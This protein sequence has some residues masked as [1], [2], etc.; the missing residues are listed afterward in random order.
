MATRILDRARV[1]LIAH[2]ERK[3]ESLELGRLISRAAA[4]LEADEDA[5]RSLGDGD[6]EYAIR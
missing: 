1:V 5:I 2:E 3:Q 6:G 4:P